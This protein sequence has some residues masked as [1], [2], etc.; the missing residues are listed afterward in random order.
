MQKQT[1][2]KKLDKFFYKIHAQSRNESDKHAY[3]YNKYMKMAG[4]HKLLKKNPNAGPSLCTLKIRNLREVELA[5][6]QIDFEKQQRIT[7]KA[8][9]QTENLASTFISANSK[10]VKLSSIEKL[11]IEREPCSICLNKHDAKKI[12]RTNCDHYFG[13]YCFTDYVN[14]NFDNDRDIV[15]PLCRNQHLDSFTKFC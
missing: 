12:I 8:Y 15:C 7:D 14:T 11:C 4:I 1:T 10:Y 9:K 5:L 2:T 6:I 3:L 13:K